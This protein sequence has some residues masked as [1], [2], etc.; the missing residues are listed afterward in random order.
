MAKSQALNLAFAGLIS[1]A[2]VGAVAFAQQDTRP[3]T[4]NQPVHKPS[5]PPTCAPTPELLAN[6][7]DPTPACVPTGHQANKGRGEPFLPKHFVP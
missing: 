1:A 2:L 7:T 5:P 4:V 3:S 6:G